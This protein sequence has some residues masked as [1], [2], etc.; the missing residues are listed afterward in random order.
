VLAVLGT[1][2]VETER[3]AQAWAEVSMDRLEVASG[4]ALR[5]AEW[6]RVLYEASCRLVPQE[7]SPPSARWLCQSA[8]P[9]G[10]ADSIPASILAEAEA[11][12]GI[13]PVLTYSLLKGSAGTAEPVVWGRGSLVLGGGIV[14]L[15]VGV[16]LPFPEV[17]LA[18]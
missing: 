16:G 15:V 6:Q 10:D 2:P 18:A 11:S 5:A 1:D 14:G 17:A 3:M 13:L 7:S 9:E 12:R 4:H 8:P